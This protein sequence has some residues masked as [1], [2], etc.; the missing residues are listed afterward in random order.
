MCAAHNNAAS[1]PPRL[2]AVAALF[3]DLD[4]TLIDIAPRPELVRVPPGLPPLLERLAEHRGGALALVS[5]RPLADLDRLLAPWRGAAAGLHGAER[6]RAD[7][8]L[9]PAGEG[10][11]DRAATAALAR[12]RPDLALLGGGSPGVWLEDKGRT[13]ALHYRAAPEKGPELRAALEALL[14]SAGDG[15]RLIAGKMVLELQPAHLGKHG[16]IAAFLAEP[17]FRGRLPVFLGDD[18]TDEDGFVE[19][20]RRGGLSIRIGPPLAATAAHYR[21]ADVAAARRWLRD[22]LSP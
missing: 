6:R 4:G 22:A 19:I 15:L 11:T 1:A 2:D 13:L 12:L 7:G 5:G 21:L 16:A 14:R 8:S 18:T 3:I 17:P 20:N 10:P 9:A